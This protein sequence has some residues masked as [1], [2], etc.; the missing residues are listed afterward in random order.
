MFGLIALIS[1]TPCTTFPAAKAAG[2][3]SLIQRACWRFIAA[4][5]IGR[6]IAAKLKTT[7]RNQRRK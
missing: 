5:P 3:T 4:R 2:I 7:L 1:P 6:A